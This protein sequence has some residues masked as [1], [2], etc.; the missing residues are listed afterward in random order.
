[1]IWL[2]LVSVTFLVLICCSTFFIYTRKNPQRKTDDW[3]SLQDRSVEEEVGNQLESFLRDSLT[4][5]YKV[6]KGF[7]DNLGCEVRAGRKM[8]SRP[9]LQILIVFYQ[10]KLSVIVSVYGVSEYR[11]HGPDSVLEVMDMIKELPI[12]SDRLAS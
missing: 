7:I 11:F 9:L 1:M 5:R 2:I 12:M 3:W 10:E 6:G 4:S 8:D